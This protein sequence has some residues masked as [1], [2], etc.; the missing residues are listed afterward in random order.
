M[1]RTHTHTAID[2]NAKWKAERNNKEI[3]MSNVHIESQLCM[4]N[5]S[6]YNGLFSQCPQTQIEQHQ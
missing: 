6:W 5:I 2:T 3:A 4:L 1:K